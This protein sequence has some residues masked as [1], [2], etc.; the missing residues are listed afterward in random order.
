MKFGFKDT[1]RHW[2]ILCSFFRANITPSVW[3][4]HALFSCQFKK[5]PDQFAPSYFFAGF[6]CR[7]IENKNQAKIKTV[8]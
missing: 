3:R 2:L 7:A 1:Q 5:N 8:Q 4:L 6:H